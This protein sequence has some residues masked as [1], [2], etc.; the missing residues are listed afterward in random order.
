MQQPGKPSRQMKRST[1][2]RQPSDQ[3]HNIALIDYCDEGKK[4]DPVLSAYFY[5]FDPSTFTLTGLTP[6]NQLSSPQ[7]SFNLTSF[8]Y[9]TG[10]WGDA[11][12]P[13]SDPRQEVVAFGLKRFNGGPTG[14]R[15]KELVRKGLLP[16]R[17]RTPGWTEWA[18]GI[19]MSLY[20]CCLKGW[21]AF[22]SM[23]FVVTVLI[24]VGLAIKVA[25]KRVRKDGTYQKL[26]GEDI[27]LDDLRRQEEVLFSSSDEND[28]SD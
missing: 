2:T 14:P 16:G 25:L 6:P 1:L 13:E 12:Y 24:G 21:R 3:V 9:F 20:P 23:G 5:R 22:I 8:F 15:D 19:Y 27:P 4:W 18:V 7:S 28:D 17:K 26:Q 11:Q 10:I